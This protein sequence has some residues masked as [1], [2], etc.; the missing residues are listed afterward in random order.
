MQIYEAIKNLGIFVVLWQ[1]QKMKSLPR[2]FL[3]WTFVFLY[4]SVRFLLE[5]LK[6]VPI[7][8]FGLKWG[9]V[10]SIPMVLIG[11]YMLWRLLRNKNESLKAAAK[12]HTSEAK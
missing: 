8:A 11:G 2:G 9:Q 12:T 10:W 5:L 6:D 3:F 4:G 1:L 7:V